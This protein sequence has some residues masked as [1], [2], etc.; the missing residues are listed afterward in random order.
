MEYPCEIK[1]TS[2]TEL[3]DKVYPPKTAIIENFLYNGT[4]LFVGAPKVGKS[5]L[6]AQLAYHISLGTPLWGLKTNQ[7]RVLY[8]ALEDDE[9]RI[10]HRMFQMYGV[11]DCDKCHFATKALQINTGLEHQ[12]EY[13]L[14]HYR[15]TKVII[16]D[17]LQKIRNITNDNYSYASDYEIVARL[18]AFADRFNICLLL[19]HHTRKQQSD[20]SFDTI[21]GTNG[22]LGA[23]DGAFVLQKEKRTS[24]KAVLDIA[25]RDQ[26]A[27]RLFLSFSENCIWNL[28]KREN[29][30]TIPPTDPILDK[31]GSFVN[32]E[33]PVWSGTATQLAEVLGID[34]APC[35]LTRYLNANISRLLEEYSI[36]YQVS[37]TELKREIKLKK[38]L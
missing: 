23:A 25:G 2:L 22:L 12:L 27:Q 26:Q 4:Y 38:L 21:S 20:D 13:F 37:R 1:T 28:D 5:F 32:E 33:K 36:E 8:L 30:I 10:Q 6:M 11:S 15:D 18:K 35:A 14:F 3:F 29:N 9:A 17:T 24:S 7:G 16:I 31:I 34:K 19:V